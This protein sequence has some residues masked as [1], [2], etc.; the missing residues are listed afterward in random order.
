MRHAR[1]RLALAAGDFERAYDEALAA[2][3][4]REQQGREH[5]TWTPWRSTAALALAHLGR[6]D[7]AAALA[8]A[9]LAMAER[10]GAPRADR[11][12]RCTRARWPSPTRRRGSRCASAR[13]P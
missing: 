3:A 4:L 10:F 5:P 13:W 1:A 9:E 12:V 7:E 11:A 2:G 6:R 8:D